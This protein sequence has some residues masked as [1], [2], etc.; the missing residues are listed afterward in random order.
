MDKL[1]TCEEAAVMLGI[2]VRGVRFRAKSAGFKRR[3]SQWLFSELEMARM[4]AS[5]M[6]LEKNRAKEE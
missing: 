3:Y 5:P 1:Y 4:G 2:T 6:E